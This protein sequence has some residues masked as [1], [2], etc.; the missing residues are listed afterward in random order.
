[1]GQNQRTLQV[2]QIFRRD[3]GLRQQAK[4]GIDTVG[5]PPFGED[6]VN[7]GHA[8]INRGKRAAIEGDVQRVAVNIA[9]LRQAQ[10]PRN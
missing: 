7:A 1:M 10:L 2:L 8:L 9:E 4:T 5:G 3:T 6:G